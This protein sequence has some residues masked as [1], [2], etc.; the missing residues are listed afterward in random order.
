MLSTHHL[1]LRVPLGMVFMT[2]GAE[3]LLAKSGVDPN[4][5]LAR[6]ARGD[7]G[8]MDEFDKDANEQALRTRNQVMSSYQL[9]AGKC[10]VVTAPRGTQTTIYLPSEH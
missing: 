8:D 2:P 4:E 5:L 7:W 1:P 3:A 9:A 10:Y 6:H